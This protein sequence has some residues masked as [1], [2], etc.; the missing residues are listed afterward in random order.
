[1]ARREYLNRPEHEDKDGKN[2]M[3]SRRAVED[4]IKEG[5]LCS[6]VTNTPRI[7]HCKQ[8]RQSET[9]LQC[10]LA[11]RWV[12]FQTTVPGA[13]RIQAELALQMEQNY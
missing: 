2:K 11:S 5:L 6:R 13:K 9:L 10:F 12:R 4:H 7:A 8:F 3:R 1:M